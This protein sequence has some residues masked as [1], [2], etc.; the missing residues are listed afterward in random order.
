MLVSDRLERCCSAM[1]PTI[2]IAGSGQ[3]E[4]SSYSW[5][6]H[7]PRAGSARR[8]TQADLNKDPPTHPAPPFPPSLG[9][10][11]ER[12]RPGEGS[13]TAGSVV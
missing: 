7:C 11:E 2:S 4:H 10:R 13:P 5:L 9:Q 6:R 3:V 8:C 1:Y 12:R